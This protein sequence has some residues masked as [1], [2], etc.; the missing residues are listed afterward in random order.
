M[1]A[2]TGKRHEEVFSLTRDQLERVVMK[3]MS[4][5]YHVDMN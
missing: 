2:Y 5:Q 3:N 4:G 1:I